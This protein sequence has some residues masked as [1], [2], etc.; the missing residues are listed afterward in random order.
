LVQF[1]IDINQTETLITWQSI[2]SSLIKI[3]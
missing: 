3:G 2:N 1:F